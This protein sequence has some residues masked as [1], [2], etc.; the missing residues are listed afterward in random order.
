MLPPL[1]WI[2]PS[3][4]RPD[5]RPPRDRFVLRTAEFVQNARITVEQGGAVLYRTRRASFVPNRTITLPDV[6]LRA[7][8]PAGGPVRV[9]IDER[10]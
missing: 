8:R 9:A 4:V 5:A 2:C 10:A 1:T 3:M 6:W 7:V